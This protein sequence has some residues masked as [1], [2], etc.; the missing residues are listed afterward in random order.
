MISLQDIAVHLPQKRESNAE[1]SKLFEG[2]SFEEVAQRVGV[3]EKAIAAPD[4]TALDLAE[5]A[6]L[7]L[8]ERVPDLAKHIDLLIF[9][10]Q[11][12]DYRLPGNASLLH[13]RLNLASHAGAFDINLACS[14]YVYSL[15][16]AKA[17]MMAGSAKEVLVVTADTYSKYLDPQDRSTR[18]LF[19]DGA[20]VTWLNQAE[21]PFKL[22][23]SAWGSAGKGHEAFYLPANGLRQIDKAAYIE[24]QGKDMLKFT[25]STIPQHIKSFL[26][27]QHLTLDDID[28]VIFHQ[29][30]ALILD[31]LSSALNLK[32]EK[33]F[34]NLSHVGNLVSASILS[35]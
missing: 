1:L 18:L 23:T 9:C 32:P 11:S 7:K 16:I 20:A 2:F 13:G 28:Q 17:L 12:P 26:A 27:E 4:E 8:F 3:F 19:G 6:C 22:L 21:G 10:T 34:R 29:A 35:L 5:A 24:M 31:F 30:S 15:G 33:V 25:Y 14:G